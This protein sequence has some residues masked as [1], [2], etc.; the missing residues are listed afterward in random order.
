MLL[1]DLDIYRTIY[2]QSSTPTCLISPAGDILETNPAHD[3][4]FCSPECL[5]KG[6]SVSFCLNPEQFSE[7]TDQLQ[8]QG[9]FKKTLTLILQN[10]TKLHIEI[11]ATGIKDKENNLCVVILA[12]RNLARHRESDGQLARFRRMI[13]QSN[14]AFFVIDAV[15]S[16]VL[17]FNR[18]VRKLWGYS[19]EEML[20]LRIIDLNPNYK[21]LTDWN[22]RVNSI[23]SNQASYFETTHKT[24]S[25]KIFPVEISH[26]YIEEDGRGFII[27]VVRDLS[28]RQAAE[29]KRLELEEQLRQK[30]KM[31][32]VGLL[33]GGVAH[34]FNNSLAIILG[35][36]EMAQRKFSD[37]DKV[38]VCI[39]NAQ[40]AVIRSR[41]LVNQILIYS[42]KGTTEKEPVRFSLIVDETLKL[43]S[44]TNPAT[45][46]LDFN[47]FAADETRIISADSSQI[48]EILINLYNNAIYA[49]DGNGEIIITLESV[50][51]SEKDVPAQYEYP[52][53]SYVK[54]SIQDNGSGMNQ[55]QQK[56][57]FDPFFTTKTVGE[58]TGMGLSTV[59]GIVVQHNGF[60]KVQSSL[61]TGTT[62][63]LYFPELADQQLASET[64]GEVSQ[65][66]GNILLVDDEKMLLDLVEEMLTEIGYEVT[67]AL[68]GRQALE[69]L[70]N[71]PDK[72]DLIIT[73]QTMPEMT[74]KELSQKIKQQGLGL[75]IVLCSGY[76]SDIAE[77]NITAFC[78]K[79][80]RLSELSLVIRKILD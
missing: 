70:K 67:T 19:P 71:S 23:Q 20:Q 4:L 79:P 41:D 59:Q 50:K 75:P 28:D 21:S 54:L 64:C 1:A 3:H 80:L 73:D 78:S 55:E 77:E 45:V 22:H 62:F 74:G 15:T 29:E 61:G 57:I 42:R 65:G 48:Q 9:L 68:S 52:S 2:L 69:L 30:Y 27:A 25:G 72:F 10:Q 58:G 46:K 24:K 31:E 12:S 39:E 34:N 44:S 53:G 14:D 37:P 16:K 33:A 13:E 76:N 40:T 6:N 38:K 43:L 56:K 5:E 36:L 18:K 60:I 11:A 35:N 63:E 7:L 66:T 51:L 8:R 32:A 47:I 49:M 17:D 26:Q